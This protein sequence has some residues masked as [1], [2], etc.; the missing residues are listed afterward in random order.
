[1]KKLLF[2]TVTGGDKHENFAVLSFPRK[3]LP[4][5][6]GKK[7]LGK[8]SSPLRVRVVASLLI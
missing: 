7:F 5:R 6:L 4:P 1:M 2:P 3:P 8:Y